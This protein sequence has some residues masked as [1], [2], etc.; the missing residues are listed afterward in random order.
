[1]RIRRRVTDAPSVHEFTAVASGNAQVVQAGRDVNVH[2]VVDRRLAEQRELLA[3]DFARIELPES[4]SFTSRPPLR[5]RVEDLAFLRD[6]VA[7]GRNV[8]L[9]GPAGVGKTLL[10]QHAASTGAL[11]FDGLRVLWR[12]VA[13]F[14][15][16][17]DVVRALVREC[18]EVPEQAVLPPRLARRLLRDV[19]ALVVLDGLN[20]PLDHA[21][22]VV[23]SMPGSVVVV[24]T[25]REDLW[26]L[27]RQRVLAGLPLD[28]VLAIV[29]EELGGPPD[30]STVESDWTDCAGNPGSVLA[31]AVLRDIA[32]TLGVVPEE[33]AEVES[34]P[35]VVP[36]VVDSLSLD[37]KAVLRAL[38][39]LGDVEWGG[40]LLA[41]V[42]GSP[43]GRQAE[44]LVAKRLARRDDDR[45]HVTAD[46]A[47]P[48]PLTGEPAV[49]VERITD[50]VAHARP[51][52]VAGNVAVVARALAWSLDEKRNDD[53]L[54]LAR[55]ASLALARSWHWGALALV[56]TLGLRAA[57]SAGSVL[58]EKSFRYTLAL[59]RLH[60][61]QVRQAAE[62]LIAAASLDDDGDEHLAARV[63][64]VNAE[65]QH[66]A[67]RRP[68]S[69][70]DALVGR[71]A[72]AGGVAVSTATA[73]AKA[74]RD[75]CVSALTSSPTGIA[76]VRLAQDNPGIVRG[77]AS[78]AAVGL[79]VATMTASG[80]H[81]VATATAPGATAGG[82]PPAWSSGSPPTTT[83][84]ERAGTTTATP[85][86][87]APT[88]TGSA[89]G[90]PPVDA[91]SAEV[92]PTTTEESRTGTP[93]HPTV[94][95]TWGFARVWYDERPIGTT[96][97]LSAPNVPDNSEANWTYGPWMIP[98]PPSRSAT[99][100]HT[101]VGT[102]RV[103]LPGVGAPGGSVKVTVQDYFGAWAARRGYVP[104]VFCQPS[105]W[106]Q[107]GVDEVIDV[108][109]FDRDGLPTD[110]AFFVRYVAG[111]ASGT[112]G[113]VFDD[114]P[115][116]ATFT[117]DWLHGVSAG[118][119]T[120]T[121]VGRYTADLPGSA[122]GAVEVTAVGSQPRHCAVTGRRGQFADIACTAPGGAAA[123]SMF[124]AGF[125]VEQNM[126]D[127]P[128]KPVGDYLISEDSPTAAA[129][130]I[131]TRWASG[132]APMTLERLATGRYKAHFANGYINSTMHV[133]STAYGNHCGIMQLNDHSFP[134]DATIWVACFDS[135][136]TPV[137][138]GFTLVYTSAR[139]S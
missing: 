105:G 102:E 112:R 33:A 16:A 84:S 89:P 65:V 59:L 103:R 43:G 81:D 95:A 1:M 30:A 98:Y 29:G 23:S 4:V 129:P 97:V 108:A 130:T 86:G 24:A 39:A 107:D 91:T 111:S 61:D 113:F 55:A 82:P 106:H 137:N 74:V 3:R 15:N 44:A 20:V 94:R 131:T 11:A 36:I 53:A 7:A 109:C 124:T 18:Y 73:G 67:S 99:A 127:D 118:A 19:R 116:S 51:D 13:S 26:R 34:L 71:V 38:V 17:D 119:V 12:E 75:V 79:L 49:L 60:D 78:V 35:Q 48:V 92:E 115:S 6:T 52:A 128:R 72:D 104:G 54:A 138:S 14:T 8:V 41:A 77:V 132:N 50:W 46:I 28:D 45:Y 120:R 114:Q 100:T 68:L 101:G 93:L 58:D 133:T 125:A 134:D 88:T 2:V 96:H 80:N 69:I 42:S 139:N 5:G 126:L 22:Q 47:G 64:E 66:I 76:L 135:S 31:R 37:A 63:R 85:G 123:D 21:R 136:G 121:G 90:Q 110:V 87:R 27:G 25:R 117:P 62:L 57:V 10:L 9:A 32:R 122:G 83:S 70:V 40:D 56:L